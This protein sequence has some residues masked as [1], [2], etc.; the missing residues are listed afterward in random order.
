MS[1][2]CC[3][4]SQPACCKQ[5]PTNIWV[6]HLCVEPLSGPFSPFVI[7]CRA[8]SP[9]SFSFMNSVSV[10]VL[11]FFPCFWSMYPT[12]STSLWSLFYHNIF[13]FLSSIMP[14]CFVMGFFT[15]IKSSIHLLWLLSPSAHIKFVF[16]NRKKSSRTR[17]NDRPL[18]VPEGSVGGEI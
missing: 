17:E 10:C 7:P 3:S 4:E 8:R 12:L 9:A 6:S 15:W 18:F 13:C 5:A 14:L 11:Q 1:D 2:L 16:S